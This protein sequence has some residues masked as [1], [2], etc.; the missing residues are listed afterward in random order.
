MQNN[1]AE[2][3]ETNSDHHS[4]DIIKVVDKEVQL[5]RTSNNRPFELLSDS[6]SSS[7]DSED[8]GDSSSINYNSRNSE[9]ESHS[10]DH[11]VTG[12]VASLRS[13]SSTTSV[14]KSVVSE[15]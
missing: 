8:S 14:E 10:E 6:D 9:K 3:E 4:V 2:N 11:T 13:R 1:R 15:I 12:V 7:S 5:K